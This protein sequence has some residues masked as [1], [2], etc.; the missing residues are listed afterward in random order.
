MNIVTKLGGAALVVALV[1]GGAYGAGQA[2]GPLG[3][4]PETTHGDRHPAASE[5]AQ[6]GSDQL[7]AGGLL[8]SQD[9]YRLELVSGDAT[10]GAPEEFAFRILGSDGAPVTRFMPTHDKRMHL[11]VARRDLSGFQHVHPTM[12]ADGTWRIPMT[13]ETAGDYRAFA[14]FAPEGRSEAITLGTDVAV[15]GSYTPAALPA[16]ARTATVDGYTVRMDG[17]LVPGRTGK[18]TLTVSRDGRP[19]TDLQP[20]LAAYGHLVALRDGDL[21]YLHVHPDGVP[22]DGRTRPGPQITFYAEVPS[23]G[24]YRLVVDFRHQDVVRT[25]AFT[26]AADPAGTSGAGEVGEHGGH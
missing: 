10:A 22:G 12:G 26:A 15:S 18:L 13:F 7:P 16:P 14:D 24:S 2:A 4:E 17:D 11:I 8:V 5:A 20:H 25:A 6:T 21:A 3:A 9:G 1:F 23:A 19:V